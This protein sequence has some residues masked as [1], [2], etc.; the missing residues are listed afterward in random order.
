MLVSPFVSLLPE[1]LASQ[2]AIAIAINP[3]SPEE[4]AQPEASQDDNE[5]KA[6]LHS[7][8]ELAH[9]RISTSV[10][11]DVAQSDANIPVNTQRTSSE[12]DSAQQNDFSTPVNTRRIPPPVAP[13]PP[14]HLIPQYRGGGTN[15]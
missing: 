7:P 13:R 2:T 15:T 1:T 8:E 10:P 3:F 6:Q 14:K 9:T 12:L 11:A 4:V 5:E